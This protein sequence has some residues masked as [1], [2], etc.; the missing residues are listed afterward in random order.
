MVVKRLERLVYWQSDDISYKHY[1][2]NIDILQTRMKKGTYAKTPVELFN[3]I[4]SYSIPAPV[5]AKRKKT[6]Q[7]VQFL[8]IDQQNK[9]QKMSGNI[10]YYQEIAPA[11]CS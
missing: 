11:L 4:K 5:R 10:F 3:K 7:R 9:V 8:L 6:K 1:L 2:W